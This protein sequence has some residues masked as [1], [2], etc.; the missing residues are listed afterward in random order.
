MTDRQREEVERYVKTA[1]SDLLCSAWPGDVFQR[2]RIATGGM[3]AALVDEV[4]KRAI[5]TS[6]H[7]RKVRGLPRPRGGAHLPQLQ[8]THDGAPGNVHA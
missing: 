3:R 5:G 8:A 1:E 6:D 4:L 2:S 7:Q